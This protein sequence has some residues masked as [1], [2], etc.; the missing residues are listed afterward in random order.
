MN[1]SEEARPAVESSRPPI[2]PAP[3]RPMRDRASAALGSSQ[4]VGGPQPAAF[5][6]IAIL[7]HVL[8]EIDY[9]VFLV[10]RTGRVLQANHAALAACG[11]RGALRLRDGVLAACSEGDRR[12]LDDALRRAADG[13]RSLLTLAGPQAVTVA[14]V[15]LDAGVIGAS[16]PLALLV[17]GK[18]RVCEPLTM[19]L[20]ARAHRLTPAE[21]N[22]LTALCVGL[23]PA[24]IAGRGG[25]TIE[26]IRTQIKSV[27]AKTGTSSILD[28]IER[29]A[30]L[31]PLVSKLRGADC[32]VAP[33]CSRRAAS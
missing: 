20:F 31:P 28:L 5:G 27:R 30:A 26:T 19:E 11:D 9:G 21:T 33:A 23:S 18:R 7:A 13:S 14:V 24:T 15:P 6:G 10:D 2:R 4:P 25:V 8:D 16:D 12:S 29:V 1:L 3:D 17:L 32:A 22:V